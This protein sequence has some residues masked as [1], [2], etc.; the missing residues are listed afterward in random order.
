MIFDRRYYIDRLIS[1]RKN[2]MVKIITGLRRAGK[3]FLLFDLYKKYLLKN[4]YDEA[5]IITINFDDLENIENRKVKN[6]YNLIKSKLV[7]KK[8]Y[9]ILL[10]EI[11]FVDDFVPM[12]NSLL[13]INNVDCYVT[14]SNSKFLSKDVVTEFRGRGDEIH[15]FPLTFKEL[16][17][18]YDN[19]RYK[20]FEDYLLYGG[21]PMVYVKNSELDR[22][23]YLK[24]IFSETYIIDVLERYNIKK[25]EE[26]DNL[27][28]IISSSIGSFTS[29]QN[30]VN[31]FKTKYNA[32]ISI[33]TIKNYLEILK[34][35]FLVREVEKYDIKG[36]KYIGAEKKYY[37]EDIGLRNARIGFRQVDKS[38]IMENIIFNELIKRRY[39]V[40]VGII[41]KKEVINNMRKN[42]Q[43]EVDFIVEQGH[44][45]YY[46][47]S[48]YEMN[49][50][51]KREQEYR[52]LKYVA[53]S[54][55]KIVIRYDNYGIS[56]DENGILN[57]GL[58]D[59]L[60][61]EDCFS[62]E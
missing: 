62:Y 3:S 20:C 37:Y 18:L 16:L 33:P 11:Q 59:F 27:L 36:R 5:H 47:Q 57:I 42:R 56:L 52:S 44:T 55:K 9:V 14:G 54:F 22:T 50:E 61:N 46:V 43:Y 38:H 32:K 30:I 12:L 24:N 25:S 15:L 10:D 23:E 41:K 17:P 29:I 4:G 1:K 53:D 19:D 48:A 6:A 49:T 13:H 31:T 40:D 26:L 58:F 8:E 28:S 45:K 21:L 60:L 7:D 39:E 35:I 34:D 2:G 51:K